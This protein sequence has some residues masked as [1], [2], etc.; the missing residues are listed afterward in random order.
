M[1][2]LL[3]A[4]AIFILAPPSSAQTPSRKQQN[5]GLRLTDVFF[6]DFHGAPTARWEMRPGEEVVL[7][8][9]IDGFGRQEA[10]NKDGLREQRVHLTYEITLHDPQ[11]NPVAPAQSDNIE[12]AL[13]PQDAEWRPK[14]RWSARVPSAVPGGTYTIAIHVNDLIAKRKMEKAVPFRVIGP[15]DTAGET[16]QISQ[17]EYSNSERGPWNPERYFAPSETIWVRYRITGFRVSPEKQVWVEQDWTVLD[18]SGKAV[19]SQLNAAVTNESNFYPP[20]FL[21]TTFTLNLQNAKPGKYT[22]RIVARDQVS[23]ESVTADSDFY[24]RP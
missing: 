2:L 11:G 5:S 9:R 15:N 10:L 13:T 17:V 19:V 22:L 7:N 16:L 12:T 23:G 14:I 8:F 3:A 20:R 6:E 18:E 4:L 21:P 1:R 24:I